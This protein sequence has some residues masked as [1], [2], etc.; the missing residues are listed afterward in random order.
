MCGAGSISCPP[1]LFWAS[2]PSTSPAI[3]STG[4]VRLSTCVCGVGVP[5][6]CPVRPLPVPSAGG[7]A[8]GGR[9]LPVAALSACL[10][11]AGYDG[12]ACEACAPGYARARAAGGAAGN[13]SALCLRTLQ[14]LRQQ[15]LLAADMG[16]KARTSAQAAARVQP[17]R[18]SSGTASQ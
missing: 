14:G 9:G 10:C 11:W 3:A 2:P 5:E 15:A 12:A 17:G 16:A 1:T 8:C 6:D 13:A 7:A 4:H 18:G